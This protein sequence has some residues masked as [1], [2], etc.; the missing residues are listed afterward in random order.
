[1]RINIKK[2]F[3]T[4]KWLLRKKKKT[5]FL[6]AEKFIATRRGLSVKGSRTKKKEKTKKNEQK[7]EQ[8]NMK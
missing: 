4:V 1:M 3:G 6:S 5:R 2:S 8:K 7:I